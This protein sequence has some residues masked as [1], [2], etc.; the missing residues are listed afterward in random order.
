[1]T[2]LEV[3]TK[4]IYGEARGERQP[5][6]EAVAN[7][8]INRAKNP[9]W[10]GRDVVSVCLKPKQFSCWNEDDP[11]RRVL[12]HNLSGDIVY[13][14]CEQIARRALAGQL[15]DHT[16]GATHYHTK[17]VQPRWAEHLVPCADIGHHLFYKE[18]V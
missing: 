3:L 1:M 6:M 9:G 15:P 11:N 10:W 5:G 13:R 16:N 17:S 2:E 14:L 18:V 12:E 4:T 8:I 7:V